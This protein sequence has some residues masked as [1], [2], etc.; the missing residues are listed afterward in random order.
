M[1]ASSRRAVDPEDNAF[2]APNALF[3]KLGMLQSD[4]DLLAIP[5]RDY[6]FWVAEAGAFACLVGY[7]PQGTMSGRRNKSATR[8]R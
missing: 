1:R 4:F 5:S 3:L 7:H 8:R 6:L 2:E